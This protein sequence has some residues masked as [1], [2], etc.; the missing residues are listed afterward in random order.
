MTDV[1]FGEWASLEGI[2][3]VN[4]ICYNR[5]GHYLAIAEGN[6]IGIFE[7]IESEYERIQTLTGI[8][9]LFGVS[10]IV[11]TAVSLRR[12]V[13]IVPYLFGSE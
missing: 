7:K 6:N 12:E 8:P 1:N 4:S 3:V 2:D 10:R 11:R 13:M 5:D 9:L